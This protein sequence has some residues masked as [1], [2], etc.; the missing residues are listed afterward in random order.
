MKHKVHIAIYCWQNCLTSVLFLRQQIKAGGLPVI[1]KIPCYKIF[2]YGSENMA[3][4]IYT[5]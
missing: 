4:L 1:V 5:K 2:T 3:W